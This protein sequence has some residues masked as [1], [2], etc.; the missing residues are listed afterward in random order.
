MF[1]CILGW[2]RARL[3]SN[4]QSESLKVFLQ[5]LRLQSLKIHLE[6]RADIPEADGHSDLPLCILASDTPITKA[7][8]SPELLAALASKTSWRRW[9]EHAL[10]QQMHLNKIVGLL[11]VGLH[12][13]RRLDAA[14]CRLCFRHRLVAHVG[15]DTVN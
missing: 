10:Q 9:S 5:L 3:S 8:A 6:V 11:T 14:T 13:G 7:L 4:F 15:S 1:E 2:L 12:E